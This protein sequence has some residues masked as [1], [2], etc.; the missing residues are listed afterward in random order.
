MGKNDESSALV[1][2]LIG[3]ARPKKP[4]LITYQ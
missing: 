4:I 1:R 3:G 2:R